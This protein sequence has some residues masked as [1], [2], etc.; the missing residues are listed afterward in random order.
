MIA[1]KFKCLIVTND[2]MRDHTFHLLGND[3]FPRWKERHQVHFRFTDAG[4]DFDMPPPCS[5]VIQ[6]SEK[7]HWHIPIEGEG[8]GEGEAE[9]E[10][11]CITRADSRTTRHS[12]TT[13]PGGSQSVGH[14]KKQARSS[15]QTRVA[16][17]PD[18][19]KHNIPDNIR[20]PPQDYKNLKNI[21]AA[22]GFPDHRTVLSEIETAE[23]LGDTV[24]DF[25]I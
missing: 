10:W 19:L 25:Q 8:E 1:I 12:I 18:R 16:I 4:P 22:S 6:E 11:L 15:M 17:K 9:R 24:I 13:T 3:F 7:G 14:G 2:E 21:L 20:K 23:E 5:V